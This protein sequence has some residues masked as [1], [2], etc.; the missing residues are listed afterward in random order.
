LKVLVTGGAGYIGSVVVDALVRSGHEV[1]VYDNLSKGHRAAIAPGV[2]LVVGD[3]NDRS[4]LASVFEL[5]SFD[6]VV[7]FAAS[8]EAGE[9]MVAPE[10]FFRNNTANTLNLLE[11]MLERKISRFVFSST[12]ALYGDPERTPI[13]ESD[14]LKPTNA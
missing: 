11:L 12:A 9:S 3:L 1:V 6:G 14:K 5:A 4:D 8:I 10:K 2:R 7:H 13:E